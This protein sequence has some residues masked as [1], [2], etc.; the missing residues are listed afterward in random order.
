MTDDLTHHGS[1]NDDGFHS[2]PGST[3]PPDGTYLR[4]NESEGW[5]D[6]DGVKPPPELLAHG[7]DEFL[8]RWKGG[9]PE[10]ITDKPLPD[11]DE[12]NA[13]IPRSE[14]EKGLTGEPR[15]P[16]AHTVAAR[17]VSPATG[18]FFTF[19]S[20]TTGAHIAIDQLKESVIGMRMMRGVPVMPRVTLSSRPMKTKFG[21]K[22][23]P[24]FDVIGWETPGDGALTTKPAPLP[25]APPTPEGK[26]PEAPT[27]APEQPKGKITIMRQPKAAVKVAT[28]KSNFEPPADFDDPIPW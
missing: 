15:P 22:T 23:R 2:S 19:S 17:L 16:W 5:Q 26:S 11:P 8:Q 14:W 24:H 1:D 9:I 12:L 27:T 18:S 7:V 28:A 25:I 10:K 13:S 21:I 3:R 4:W 6:R 20:A